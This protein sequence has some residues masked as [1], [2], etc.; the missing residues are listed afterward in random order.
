MA[1]RTA[2]VP[3]KIRL[4]FSHPRIVFPGRQRIIQQGDCLGT[5]SVLGGESEQ[6]QLLAAEAF[7]YPLAT[8][9][10]PEILLAGPGFTFAP[11]VQ[12]QDAGVA[13]IC[14]DGK[15]VGKV[16]MIYG[17]TVEYE[18]VQKR[19]FWERLFGGVS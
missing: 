2:T 12:G 15:S 1:M 19:S 5:V 6:V 14:L 7:V 18:K 8:D 16:R 3:E 9:E 10:N 11:V 13:Y 17:Q 4:I